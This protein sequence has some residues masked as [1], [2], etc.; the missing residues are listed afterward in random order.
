MITLENIRSLADRCEALKLSPVPDTKNIFRLLETVTIQLSDGTIVTLLE[1]W[2]YDG[3]SVPWI[4]QPIFPKWGLYAYNSLPH[5]VCYYCL[6][7]GRLWA[8]REHRRWGEAVGVKPMDN[9]IRFYFL[10]ALGWTAWLRSKY[11]P[12]PRARRNRG[13][14]IFTNEQ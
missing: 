8:D 13:L 6:H 12:T 3:A 5:D 9:K 11:F 7:G 2:E 1:G 10:R 4:F 14:T